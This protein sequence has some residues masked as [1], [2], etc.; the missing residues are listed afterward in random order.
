MDQ[1]SSSDLHNV[2]GLAPG[3]S[4]VFAVVAGCDGHRYSRDE[5]EAIVDAIVSEPLASSSRST[6]E[7]FNASLHRRRGPTPHPAEQA[8][9]RLRRTRQ[10]LLEPDQWGG[11]MWQRRRRLRLEPEPPEHNESKIGAAN[12][13]AGHGAP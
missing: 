3:E 12:P 1:N 10:L 9:L 8:R 5:L 6:L 13:L 2:T 7:L 4:F 11:A